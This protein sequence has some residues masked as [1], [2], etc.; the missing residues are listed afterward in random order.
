[1]TTNSIGIK[2]KFFIC[3]FCI[4]LLFISG[5]SSHNGIGQEKTALPDDGNTNFLEK[6]RVVT[7]IFPLADLVEK[8][9]GEMVDVT[10]LLAAGGSPH[11]Y[12][13]TVEQ[14]K[15]VARADFIVYIGG[16]LDNWVMKLAEASTSQKVIILEIMDYMGEAVL[17]Y[18]QVDNDHDTCDHDHITLDDC[19]D[20]TDH[21]DCDH[22][23]DHAAHHHHPDADDPHVWMDPILVKEVFAPLLAE[24]LIFLKPEGKNYFLD[25]MQQFQA[26]LDYLHEEIMAKVA[27][28]DQ[29]RFIS[30]HSAWKYFAHRYGLEEVAT[31]EEFPGKEP[32]AKWLVE[33]VNLA[34]LHEI[35]VLFAEPQLSGK[36]AKVIADEIGGHVYILDPLGGR[37]IP[38][39]DCYL[40]LMR[41]NA[42]IFEEALKK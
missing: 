27:G 24:Y 10:T 31:V 30:Y 2:F 23:L 33:L 6:V 16:G 7:S 29:K 20:H 32:S 8:I 13:P 22:N 39:R 17:S 26:E 37:G 5:C 4:F 38:G 42:G 15:A 36:A 11:T 41:Y 14:A 21:D 12:E 19:A 9:G 28:F 18:G 3:I 35:K 34:D 25:N 40:Q 1:M